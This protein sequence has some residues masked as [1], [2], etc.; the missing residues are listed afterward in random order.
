MARNSNETNDTAL[1]GIPAE[2]HPDLLIHGNPV[3]PVNVP[4]PPPHAPERYVQP[5]PSFL[6]DARAPQATSPLVSVPS[7]YQP[8][9]K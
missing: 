2:R 6:G 4:V 5:L 8:R 3:G 1:S 7:G 9:P